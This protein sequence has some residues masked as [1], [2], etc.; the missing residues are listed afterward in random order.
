MCAQCRD[1]PPRQ[2]QQSGNFGPQRS[3]HDIRP[4]GQ[5]RLQRSSRAGHVPSPQQALGLVTQQ[6]RHE[7]QAAPTVL[8]TGLGLV[9]G[10]SPPV[11][12]GTTCRTTAQ[13]PH[14]PCLNLHPH[15]QSSAQATSAQNQ[16]KNARGQRTQWQRPRR[17]QRG[18]PRPQPAAAEHGCPRRQ[19]ASPPPPR[20]LLPP[21]PGLYHS[22]QRV[23]EAQAQ[24]GPADAW[25]RTQSKIRMGGC[26]PGV[27]FTRHDMQRAPTLLNVQLGEGEMRPVSRGAMGRREGLGQG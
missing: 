23:G 13:A 9:R 18:Q 11:P 14:G 22:E 24:K 1:H 10:S 8:T 17:R 5:H 19:A 16:T 15:V 4:K 2:H 21:A 20:S 27:S 7:P 12:T 25:M 6:L 26:K 3:V